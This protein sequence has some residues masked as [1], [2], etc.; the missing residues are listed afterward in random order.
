[1]KK[2]LLSLLTAAMMIF[3]AVPAVSV[4]SQVSAISPIPPIYG[5][6]NTPKDMTTSMTRAA[7]LLF[8][9]NFH[10]LSV[11]FSLL[12]APEFVLKKRHNFSHAADFLFFIRTGV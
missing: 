12:K 11:V 7:G 8:N 5:S 3:T 10:G 9:S 2:R 4:F 6:F 1:M